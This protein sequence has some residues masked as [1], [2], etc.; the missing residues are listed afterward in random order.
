MQEGKRRLGRIEGLHRQMHQ[1]GGILADRI[2]HDRLGESRR[3]LAE[4]V[5]RLGF[6]PVEMGQSW[7]AW[8]PSATQKRRAGGGTGV[9]NQ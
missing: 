6:E 2:E 4:D 5:D 3:D 7:P 1:H 8:E 9:E